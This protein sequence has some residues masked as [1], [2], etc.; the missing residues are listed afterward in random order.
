MPKDLFLHLQLRENMGYPEEGQRPSSS[1]MPWAPSAWRPPHLH[2]NILVQLALSS[3][4]CHHMQKL[5]SDIRNNIKSRFPP[6]T[7]TESLDAQPACGH[8]TP[9]EMP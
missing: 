6:G 1:C 4:L 9:A 7:L 3:R 8:E 2:G 5:G